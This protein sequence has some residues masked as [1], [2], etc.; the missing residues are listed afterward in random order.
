MSPFYVHSMAWVNLVILF[1]FIAWRWSH[2]KKK[3]L[4]VSGIRV[5]VCV[6]LT[7]CVLGVITIED[8]GAAQ[9]FFAPITVVVFAYI[10]RGHPPETP[11][12][13]RYIPPA[14][15]DP[16]PRVEPTPTSSDQLAE[17]QSDIRDIKQTLGHVADEVYDD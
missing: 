6:F 9:W 13:P 17:I 10:L 8:I 4:E 5:C 1:Y 14:K 15:V 3:K 12:A 2:A 16:Q 11:P 7:L